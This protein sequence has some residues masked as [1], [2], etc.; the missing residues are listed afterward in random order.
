MNITKGDMNAEFCIDITDD[1][2]LENGQ[3]FNLDINTTALH[4]EIVPGNPRLAAVIILDN[5]CKNINYS[6][7]LY[8]YTTYMFYDMY[9]YL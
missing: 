4:F 1:N 6:D 9:Y 7:H 3:I 2:E 8:L 5:E